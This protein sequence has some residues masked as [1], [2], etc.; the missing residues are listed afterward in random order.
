MYR[1][2]NDDDIPFVSFPLSQDKSAFYS[3]RQVMLLMMMV[4][5]MV[6]KSMM[7]VVIVRMNDGIGGDDGNG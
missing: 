7:M 2:L 1:A 4:M 3:H 6:M 5:L